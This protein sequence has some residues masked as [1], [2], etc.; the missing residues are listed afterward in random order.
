[1]DIT[2]FNRLTSTNDINRH[3]WEVARARIARFLLTRHNVPCNVITDVGS[4][5]AFVLKYLMD[6]FPH[7]SVI[8]VDHAYTPKIVEALKTGNHADRIHFFDSLENAL[9]HQQPT[10]ILLMDVIEHIKDDSLFMKDLV[11]ATGNE[12]NATF[13]I[14]VPAFQ[15]LFSKHDQLLF[16]FRRYNRKMLTSLCRENNLQIVT[17][18]YFFFSLIPARIIQLLAEKLSIRKPTKAVDN[19]KGGHLASKIISYILWIDFRVC[20]SL[21]RINIKLPGLSCVCICQKSAS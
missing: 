20:F 6:Y 8:A 14:T 4:G 7:S 5:D 21:S 15:A 19:W 16:H 3:P 1:M 17:S 10:C 11:K 13:L 9:A 12:H 18:G 2:E